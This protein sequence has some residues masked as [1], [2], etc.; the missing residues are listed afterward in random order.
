MSEREIDD[1]TGVETT[2][3]E[4]DG[5]RELNN[6]LPRWWLW[7]FYGSIV[8]AIG[9]TI[10]YPA[11]P[12]LSSATTGVLGYSSRADHA[13]EVAAAKAA[14]GDT[15]ARIAELPVADVAKDEGLARFASAGGNSLFK[16]YCSQCHGTG[17]TGAPGYPNLNDDE[18]IWGGTV[19]EI[20]ATIANGARAPL[21]DDTHYN[22]MPNFGSDGLLE[23]PQ[24]SVVAQQVASFTGIEGG[25]DTQEGRQLF[26]DNCSSCHGDSGQ[27]AIELGGPSLNDAIWLYG[28]SLEEI[29]AQIASPKHGVMPAWLPRL[30]DTAVKQLTIYVHGLGG[31]Q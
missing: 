26:A 5:I 19:D 12:L 29:K 15:L 28:G 25:V 24:I 7:T 22:F 1:V 13:A 31:G 3:H 30:G 20:Y 16:V 2:G 9:Y 11:W 23:G 6:P 10:A 17:A 21:N 8:F 14:Q 27:G 4:W 18:W